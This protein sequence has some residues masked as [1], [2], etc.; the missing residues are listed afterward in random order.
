M[1]A[2][3]VARGVLGVGCV[4]A[5]AGSLG[6][7]SLR[8]RLDPCGR[9]FPHPPGGEAVP[10]HFSPEGG[11]FKV[12]FPPTK[13][14]EGGEGRAGKTYRWFV[15][16]EGQYEIL[17]AE[18]PGPPRD[19]DAAVLDRLK[20]SFLAHDNHRLESE[21]DLRLG[22]HVGRELVLRN[23]EGVLIRRIY[24]AG[25]RLYVVSAA[26]SSRLEGCALGDVVRHLDTFELLEE[27]APAAAPTGAE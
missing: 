9:V 24:L 26:V 22:S 8:S 10:M 14:A 15:F 4:L 18:F 20:A 3:R 12:G 1:R 2:K 16:G 7:W 23:D 5:L 17:Y 11:G 6:C 13:P 25:G 27:G 19:P 21:R